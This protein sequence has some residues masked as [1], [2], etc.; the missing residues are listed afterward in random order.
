[1]TVAATGDGTLSYQWR[2]DGSI[3]VAGT[4]ATLTLATATAADAGV[5]EC[6]VTNTV[7]GSSQVAVSSGAILAVNS[8]PA[9]VAQPVAQSTAPGGSVV[10]MVVASGNGTL[11]YQWKKDGVEI[12]GATQASYAIPSATASNGGSY[13]C[14]V[15]NLLGATSTSTATAPAT[16]AVSPGMATPPVISTQP[17]AVTVAAGDLA[18]FA[19]V[20][21][22]D[23]T[24]TYQWRK[25]GVL[26]IGATSPSLAL[27]GV[28]LASA[29]V[30]D[31]V[32]TNSLGGASSM[33]VSAGAILSVN[34]APVILA[35]PTNQ[36]AAPSG[37]ATFTVVAAASGTLGYQWRKD[38][39]LIP[40]AT[41]SSYAV[42]SVA[43]GDVGSYDCLVTSTLGATTSSTTSNAA[44]LTIATS[45]LIA[46]QSGAQTVGEGGTASFS[47]TASGAGTLSYRWFKGSS[48]LTDGGSVSGAT[49]AT[50]TLTGAALPDAANYACL[51]SSNQ[52]GAVT[53]GTSNAAALVVVATPTIVTQPAAI[54]VA[55]GGS[56]SFGVGATSAN[57]ILSYQWRKDG[58]AI[59]GATSSNLALANVAAGDAGSYDCVVTNAIAGVTRSVT[60]GAVA[61]TVNTDV[62]L[63]TQPASVTQVQ[64][65][66][67]TLT[68]SASGAAGGVLSYQWQ[69]NGI[70]V[71]GATADS[72]VLDNLTAADAA[73]YTCAVTASLNG[74]V[75]ATVASDPA[76]VAVNT[77][78][79][80]TTAPV[81]QGVAT[82]WGATFSV[83][84][85]STGTLSYQWQQTIGGATTNVGTSST[86]YTT[87][88]IA[89]SSLAAY[90]GATYSCVITST[91][92]SPATTTTVTTT[93]VTLSVAVLPSVTIASSAGASPNGFHGGEAQPTL[94]AT[95]TNTSP[96][97]NGTVTYQWMK[98]GVAIL[99][100]T[101]Y[102]YTL[103][104][105]V[106]LADAGSYT[107]A[108]T[109]THGAAVATGTSTA[110]VMNVLAA[111]V[112]I[113][114]VPAAVYRPGTINPSSASISVSA[115]S[116]GGGP[117]TYQWQV[118]TDGGTTWNSATG[119]GAT[120][121]TYS[122][123]LAYPVGSARQYRVVI[124]NAVGGATSSTTS[125]TCTLTLYQMAAISIPPVATSVVAG[126]AASLVV[127]PTAITIPGTTQAVQ[128]YRGFNISVGVAIPGATSATLSFASAEPEDAGYYYAVVTNNL[129][130]APTSGTSTTA[131]PPVRLSVNTVPTIVTQ[132]PPAPIATEGA[133]YTLTVAASGAPNA[134]L[135]YQWW[136]DGAAIPGATGA[137]YTMA[138][139]AASDAGS[140]SCVVTSS[141][142]STT[143]LTV[144]S[145]ASTL[146]VNRKP[147]I[148]T[149]VVSG[150]AVHGPITLT[151]SATNPNPNPSYLT[152]QWKRDGAVISGAILS[153]YTIGELTSAS[154]G[155]YTCDVSSVYVY[156]ATSNLSTATATS[157]VAAVGVGSGVTTPV[158]TMGSTYTA[159]KAGIVVSTAG[160]PGA[161][162]E[163]S[164]NNC[165]ITAGT[166]SS[167]ITVTAGTNLA[168]PMTATVVVS[169]GSGGAVGTASATLV[170]AATRAKLLAPASVHPGDT[171]MKA[172]IDNQGA[173]YSWNVS[174][175][176]AITGPSTGLSLPF[177][178]N[179]GAGNGNLITLGVNVQDAVGDSAPTATTT[180]NVTTGT[181]IGKDGGIGWDLGAGTYTTGVAAAVFANGRVLAC[182]GQTQSSYT[183]AAAA[184][185]DPATRRWTRVADMNYGRTG[186]TA[187]ALPNGTIL[188]TGGASSING[189]QAWLNNAELYDPATNTW[190]V[191]ASSMGTG[192]AGHAATLL[193]AGVTAGK[194]VITGGR[195][196]AGS[197]F[198]SAIAVFQPTGSAGANPGGTFSTA[199]ASLNLPRAGH[200]ATAL[201]DG[202]VLIVGGQ[203][204]TNETYQQAEL[205]DAT[206][207][208]VS[209]W[210]CTRVGS[211]TVQ[212]RAYHTATSL[213][214]GRVLIAGG[215]PGLNTAELFDPA[216]GTFTATAGT[217]K[218]GYLSSNGNGRSQHGATRLA[219]GRVLLTGGQGG[220]D[221]GVGQSAEV[222]DPTSGLFTS[223]TPMIGGRYLHSSVALTDG[224]VM[225][226]GGATPNYSFNGTASTEIFDPAANAGA[227][228]WTTIGAPGRSSATVTLLPNGRVMLVGGQNE[229]QGNDTTTTPQT[230]QAVSRT[231]HLYDPA[232][233]TWTDGPPL[234]TARY[235]HS[236][237]VLANGK[238]LVAGGQGAQSFGGQTNLASAELYDPVANTWA[239]AASM[240]VP[241]VN[242]GMI[243]L[244]NG[245][246]LAVGGTSNGP[247][248][249][250]TELYDPGANSWAYT[251]D[252]TGQ[253]TLSEAKLY[254]SPILLSNGLV[255]VAGGNLSNVTPSGAVEV[256]DPATQSWTLLTPLAVPRTQHFPVALPDGRFVLLGG[257]VFN[258]FSGGLSPVGVPGGL[259]GA[260]EI[261]DTTANGGQ[262]ASVHTANV[263]FQTEARTN[264]GSAAA[265]LPDGRV[266]LAA[267]S[268]NSTG[269]STSE[270]Y[271]PVA[272]TL[273][274]G[275][276]LTT[277]QGN[278]VLGVS[279]SNGD[280]ML[281]GGNVS[282][283][284]TQIFRP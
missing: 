187:T 234:T 197:D 132:P 80:I 186:H 65:G 265:V 121:S 280:V 193:T 145:A 151:V 179:A 267:G 100:A 84:A 279:L 50:L 240:N 140:Y 14:V 59:A 239:P 216:A 208:N 29:G 259:S 198:A 181:W 276:N 51:V 75:T 4:S 284:V 96:A 77:I 43:A 26:V 110:I 263:Y 147:T 109:N 30:Y 146:I 6:V 122:G 141:L 54:T 158:V 83:A 243:A 104:N 194:V 5:Y 266:L 57:G 277:G 142:G 175:A 244:P 127:V 152:Y 209:A 102:T 178:A 155:N 129:P 23:G 170:A 82:G 199:P 257:K 7:G 37:A 154:A 253:T 38:L 68:L 231:T 273:T 219:D 136:K 268:I 135:A 98:G 133:S 173:T 36:V 53:T 271:D 20:A 169:N 105:A 233:G 31:C 272:D 21:T 246:V 58:A 192:R 212:P 172:S 115:T 70:D 230:S 189:V 270:I 227:G 237:V 149:P 69:K 24:V 161:T 118:S 248:V 157:P 28:T 254:L 138:S 247:S 201:N 88:P 137:S 206:S 256:F 91:L 221:Q 12:L 112:I 168:A 89:G 190:I 171:W 274:A 207:S 200:T 74:T 92:G 79:T 125:S 183:A 281:I 106:S 195:F 101:S 78:P 71:P 128:W 39:T 33:A 255:V 90:D 34:G 18:S 211:L 282:D 166:G 41:A 262:G 245:K 52:G 204:F 249:A 25:D 17:A 61:L 156:T 48:A 213:L 63:V 223:V 148:L 250:T 232:T 86:F 202:R 278:G 81:A 131:S 176:G 62:A 45:P 165:S 124:T 87:P 236:A 196:S 205:F 241:R 49:T 229:R 67:A 73:S 218:G 99:G 264:P 139:A 35:Q 76:V 191:L 95:V 275:P 225:V 117:L 261:Y 283:S 269:A 164:V 15:T 120:N 19:V 72:L 46:G 184:I 47:V 242:F 113:T 159:G 174:G 153:T 107:C 222:F 32:V 3:L 93:P 85:T 252:G 11:G 114:D 215:Q 185:Y 27:P 97:L 60:T 126:A 214:D 8:A 42:P 180:V 238:L 167:A 228:G 217:L 2:K 55:E 44:T 66:T 203:G 40:G 1:L 224:T 119:V 64:G 258:S 162:Y 235:S 260:L 251:A 9:I 177:S 130:G 182:G 111:P 220:T 116:P 160:Q 16:L 94:T 134:A 56:G 163:W 10:F 13:S 226:L 144:T 103:P 108:A 143:A 188:V 123:A 210:S 150:D 22:G